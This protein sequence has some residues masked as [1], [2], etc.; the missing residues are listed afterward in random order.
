MTIAKKVLTLI[1]ACMLLCTLLAVGGVSASAAAEIDNS[2]LLPAYRPDSEVT[3]IDDG[4]PDWAAEA[5]IAEVRAETCNGSAANVANGTFDDVKKVVDHYAKVGVNVIFLNPIAERDALGVNGS[6]YNGY[7]GYGPHTIAASLAGTKDYTAAKK[8]LKELVDYAHSKNVRILI[9]IVTWGVATGAP[10]YNEHREYFSGQSG[11]GGPAFK[12]SS[13]SPAVKFF[14]DSLT[15]LA[16]DTGIDGYRCDVEPGTSGYVMYGKVRASALKAGRKLLI[17]SEHESTR[18][19]N[20]ELV[21]DFAQWGV[22]ASDGSG[23]GMYMDTYNQVFFENNIVDLIKNGQMIGLPQ[24]WQNGGELTRFY[25][26]QMSC[27]DHPAM[28]VQGNGV[29]AGYSGILTPFIPLFFIGE[30]WNNPRSAGGTGVMYFNKINWDKSKSGENK[31]FLE[32]FKKYVRV[33]RQHP[34]IFEAFAPNIMN[35]NICKVTTNKDDEQ[36]Q[37]YARFANNKAVIVVPNVD[38][39]F[40]STVT[41]TIPWEE[42]GLKANGTYVVTDLMTGKQIDSGT[43]AELES[44]KSSVP[45]LTTGVY[46]VALKGAPTTAKPTTTT[47][48]TTTKPVDPEQGGTTTKPVDPEQGGVTEPSTAPVTEPDTA[49]VTEPDTTPVTEPDTTPDTTP[50]DTPTTAPV[51]QPVVGE[52]T[53]ADVPVGLIVG[54]VAGVVVVAAV[55]VVLLLL[56]KKKSA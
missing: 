16:V 39:A 51:T 34:D 56:K 24:I 38:D 55:V 35:A 41:V 49:P 15:A 7:S 42:A 29:Y 20:G 46:L 23:H 6:M 3:L 40:K 5:I 2:S 45:S 30:E 32:Q 13:D 22:N 11:W 21:Y 44:F 18:T 8:E 48:P 52:D 9:D 25:T 17:M 10:L 47:K 14:V 28:L 26:F 31:E 27:H 12:W 43:K 37:S 53:P 1:C 19:N 50:D 33:R 54:I 4:T 36:P